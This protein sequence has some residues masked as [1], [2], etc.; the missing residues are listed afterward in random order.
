MNKRG[1]IARTTAGALGGLLLL[2]GA[3]VAIADE[4]GDDN[5]DVNVNI[6]PIEPVGALTMA[7]AADSATLTEAPSGNENIRQFNGTLPTVTVTDD[8]AEVPADVYWYVTGQA[9]D[10]TG[11]AGAT[12]S[13]GNLGW[14]PKLL[15]AEG[16]GEV[17]EGETVPTVLDA[18]TNPTTPNNVGL[19]GEEL[20]ALVATDSQDASTVG[21]WS[22]NADLFLKTPKSVTP[23]AY[24]STLT[25]T[26]W[27]DA[28]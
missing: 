4:L 9:S 20:L 15:T 13:S 14:A 3:G 1:I 28:V 25:L 8:R 12:I 21:E 18:S 17:A 24:T 23:G 26:L 5:V 6:T 11:P 22:A 16:D 27:E 10:F 2:G 19:Q 7:V